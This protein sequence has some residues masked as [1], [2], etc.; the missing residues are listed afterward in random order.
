MKNRNLIAKPFGKL[1]YKLRSKRDFRYHNNNALTVINYFFNQFDK[2]TCLS[3]TR[4]SVKQTYTRERRIIFIVKRIAS[5]LLFFGKHNFFQ[6]AVFLSIFNSEYFF[7][8]KVYQSF[9]T[10]RIHNGGGN[11]CKIA[12]LF[13]RNCTCHFNKFKHIFLLFGKFYSRYI[14]FGSNRRHFHY[15]VINLAK[16]LVRL[17][18][19]PF[20]NKEFKRFCCT[21]TESIKQYF[22][23]YCFS[24]RK[25]VIINSFFLVRKFVKGKLAFIFCTVHSSN[26]VVNTCRQHCF[27]SLIK[28]AKVMR[29]HKSGCFK[30]FIV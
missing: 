23:F 29:F 26:F 27:Y 12:N 7:I 13:Y 17:I 5:R 2:Y 10:K 25:K 3:R 6:R 20:L 24:L 9:F 4:N 11:S 18:Q 30:H 1:R 16:N 15:G 22:A 8:K 19:H 14:N 21:V 28:G